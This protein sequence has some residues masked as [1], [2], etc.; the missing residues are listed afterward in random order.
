MLK[1]LE[2]AGAR[3]KKAWRVREYGTI[4]NVA[5]RVPEYLLQEDPKLLM[6][7][8]QAVIRTRGDV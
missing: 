8:D 4:I 5:S 1:S 2:S 7:Y 3:F 6:W